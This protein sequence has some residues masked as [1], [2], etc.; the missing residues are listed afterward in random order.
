MTL[1]IFIS[2][3]RE[4]PSTVTKAKYYKDVSALTGRIY[5]LI[6]HV[7]IT[8]KGTWSNRYNDCRI[9]CDEIND[10]VACDFMIMADG[11]EHDDR[12]IVEAHIGSAFDIP[13]CRE[14]DIE[15]F[16]KKYIQKRFNIGDEPISDNQLILIHK[17]YWR[18]VCLSCLIDSEKADK[19][20]ESDSKND[21]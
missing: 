2:T 19:N 4:I 7:D 3:P 6:D 18:P 21:E 17:K 14:A 12:C 1:N 13:C 20:V 5:R 8:F 16:L 9:L 15:S 11:W 10:I